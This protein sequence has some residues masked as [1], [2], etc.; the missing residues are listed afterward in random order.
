MRGDDSRPR[1]FVSV[2]IDISQRKRAEQEINRLR[3]AVDFS[4]ESIYLTDPKSMQL[5][6]VNE[7]ACRR[8][9]YTRQQ[10]LQRPLFELMGKTREQLSNDDDQ[11]IAAG[12]RGT[13]TEMP[14]VRSDDTQGW[15]EPYRRAVSSETGI[16]TSSLPAL[17]NPSS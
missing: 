2:L 14:H 7:T 9:G 16:A 10:L 17:Q 12:E 11:V 5:L 6:Y 3:A 1:Y 8:L 4:V 15:T 13:R